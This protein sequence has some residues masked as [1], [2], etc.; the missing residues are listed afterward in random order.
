MQKKHLP[1][2][3]ARYWTAMLV[4]SLVGTTSG[5][6][7]SNDLHM[8]FAKGLGPLAALFAAT[9]FLEQR[10]SGSTETYYW[11]AVVIAR[12]AATNLADLATHQ[13]RIDYWW[14]GACLMVMFLAVLLISRGHAASQLFSPGYALAKTDLRYWS[15][16]AIAST[17]GTNGGDLISDGLGLGFGLA[18]LLCA[19]ALAVV[20]SAWRFTS[21]R[22]EIGYWITVLT[23]R[24]SGTVMG[25]FLSSREGCNLGFS[26]AALITGLLLGGLIVCWPDGD[27]A[28]SLLSKTERGSETIS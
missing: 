22:N 8:G 9:L 18:S 2:L 4:A 12:T 11:T 14:V 10:S 15:I 1:S 27:P 24:T 23:I 26:G 7:M 17:F 21:C 13:F 19:V 25:D 20:L 5:D 16:M 28:R 3:N 6:F